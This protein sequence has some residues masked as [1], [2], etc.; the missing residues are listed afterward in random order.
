MCIH[1]QT[2]LIT[3]QNICALGFDRRVAA[4]MIQDC[5]REGLTCTPKE[6]YNCTSAFYAC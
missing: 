4:E 1:G 2:R 3:F 6:I 5:E